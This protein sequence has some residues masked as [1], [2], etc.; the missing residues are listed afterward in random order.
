MHDTTITKFAEFANKADDKDI[1]WLEK[2]AV[3]IYG[4]KIGATVLDIMSHIDGRYKD[5]GDLIGITLPE[6]EIE[7][8]GEEDF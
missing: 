1:E 7:F 2:I 5:F 4:K 3:F 6:V 8:E